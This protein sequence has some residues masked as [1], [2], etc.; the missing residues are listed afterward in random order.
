[1]TKTM[2]TLSVMLRMKTHPVKTTM[3]KTTPGTT[4]MGMT[5]MGKTIEMGRTTK[6]S[7]NLVMQ[8]YFVYVL[9]YVHH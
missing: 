8:R 6:P 7:G 9:C 3:G 1:M 2:K 5:T 4:T